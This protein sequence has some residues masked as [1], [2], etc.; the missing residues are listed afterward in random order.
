[1]PAKIPKTGLLR[2]GGNLDKIVSMVLGSLAVNQEFTGNN[3]TPSMVNHCLTTSK[4]YNI[5][6]FKWSIVFV[7]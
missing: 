3:L 4:G 7:F 5:F 6:G 1:M 2:R